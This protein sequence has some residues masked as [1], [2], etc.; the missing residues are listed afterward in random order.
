GIALADALERSGAAFVSTTRLAGR[1][2]IR[3]CILNPTSGEAHVRRV[4]E[5]FAQAPAPPDAP[6]TISGSAPSQAGGPRRPATPPGPARH[7]GAGN[8]AAARWLAGFGYP[9]RPRPGQ[10]R[11]RGRR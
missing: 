9:C 1:H 11:E 8:H 3:L 5:H 4:V 10:L 2:A 6:R 7:R